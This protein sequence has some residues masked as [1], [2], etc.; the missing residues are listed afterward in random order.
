[1]INQSLLDTLLTTRS[2]V[3]H[4]LTFLTQRTGQDELALLSQALRLGLSLLYQQTAEQAFID[5]A[6]SRSEAIAVLGLER[7]TE[8]EYARQALAQDVARG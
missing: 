1:M 3:T 2:Q 6:L 7:V 4:E 8:I 5:G